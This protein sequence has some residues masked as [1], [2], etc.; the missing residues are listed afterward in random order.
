MGAFGLA[1]LMDKRETPIFPRWS[2]FF[3]LWIV[4]LS[5]P[6]LVLPLFKTGPFAWNGLF[7]FWLAATI[8]GIW[9]IVMT[10]LLLTAIDRQTD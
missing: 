4:V 2:G 3:S 6:A 1:A 9:L 7:A 8:F 5:L 10:R